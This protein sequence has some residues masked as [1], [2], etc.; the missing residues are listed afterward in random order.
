MAKRI[1]ESTADV[2]T[3]KFLHKLSTIDH[4]KKYRRIPVSRYFLRRYIIVGHFLIPRIPIR[5]TL[6]Y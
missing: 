1:G 4:V 5:T 3:V 6:R 2:R